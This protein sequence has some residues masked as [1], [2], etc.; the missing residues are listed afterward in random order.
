MEPSST[1]F[2]SVS[3]LVKNFMVM[4]EFLTSAGPL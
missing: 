3:W 2:F 4:P 1:A